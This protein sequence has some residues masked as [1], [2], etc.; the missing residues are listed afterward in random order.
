M[1]ENLG[2]GELFNM[3]NMQFSS[4]KNWL[5]FGFATLFLMGCSR[6]KNASTFKLE[7]GVVLQEQTECNDEK[8]IEESTSSVTKQPDGYEVGISAYLDC[9]AGSVKPYLTMTNHQKA[10]L[11]LYSPQDRVGFKSSCECARSLKIKL[12]NRLEAGDT[13]YL[14]RDE[15]VLGHHILP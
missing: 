11:V 1:S 14:V 9:D 4:V 15:E 6:E 10:T 2:P 13:L 5:I 12:T 3:E 7:T 8:N